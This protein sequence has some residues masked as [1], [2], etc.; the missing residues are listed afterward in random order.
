MKGQALMG[1]E[2]E[3]MSLG[4]SFPLPGSCS[5]RRMQ[6]GFSLLM[7]AGE[8]PRGRVPMGKKAKASNSPW[9]ALWSPVCNLDPSLHVREWHLW[10]GLVWRCGLLRTVCLYPPEIHTFKL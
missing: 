2:A 10:T 4:L 5:F 1:L 7:M 9:M 8:A 3:T 6:T